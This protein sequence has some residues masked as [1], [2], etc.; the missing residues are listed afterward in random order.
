MLQLPTWPQRLKRVFNI[1]IETC[2]QCGGAV[3]IIACIEDS[4]VMKKILDPL[5]AKTSVA[6]LM[7]PES[8]APPQGVLFN[9]P[10]DN[11]RRSAGRLSP[12]QRSPS[13]PR[14]ARS[15]TNHSKKKFCVF[16]HRHALQVPYTRR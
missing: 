1:D 10:E 4:G 12:R 5:N 3:K 7:R 2:I 13:T 8:R 11:P 6:T 9:G 14:G 15:Q 16:Y